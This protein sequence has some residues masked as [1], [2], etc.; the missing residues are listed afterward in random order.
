MCDISSNDLQSAQQK[1][2]ILLSWPR[3]GTNYFLAVYSKIFPDDIVFDE[4]FRKGG[5]NL[6]K[7]SYTLK[8]DK[9]KILELLEKDPCKLWNM[10]EQN[11]SQQGAKAIVKVFYYHSSNASKLWNNFRDKNKIIHLIRRN[12]FDAFLSYKIA[13]QT[14]VWK[15]LS[16]SGSD[17]GNEKKV[18]EIVPF[19]VSIA[20]V[21]EFLARRRLH[22]AR[23]RSFFSSHDFKEI[24]YEDISSSVE[25]CTGTIGNLFGVAIPDHPIE[26]SIRKQRD[27]DSRELLLNYEDVASFDRVEE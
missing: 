24:F 13:T 1:N 3:S 20:E 4:I 2:S 23:C 19:Q 9:I 5:D 12:P 15:V 22:M 25:A 10:I 11:A 7:L 6:A 26:I 21:E 8:I 18:P 27:R 14:G 17:E 16:S